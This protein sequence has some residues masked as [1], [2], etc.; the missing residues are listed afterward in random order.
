MRW[1]HPVRVD[2]VR[3]FQQH[4]LQARGGRVQLPFFHLF[5][6]FR[7]QWVAD[8]GNLF[9]NSFFGHLL[10]ARFLNGESDQ[11]AKCEAA[12]MGP[13]RDAGRLAKTDP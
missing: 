1:K 13:M 4:F 10:K 8:P 7:E 11:R 3:L 5:A 12:D 6:G 2:R 9:L